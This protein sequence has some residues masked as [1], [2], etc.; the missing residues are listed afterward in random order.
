MADSR[1]L[2]LLLCLGIFF[3]SP[4]FAKPSLDTQLSADKISIDEM[5]EFTIQT[6]WPRQEAQY[7]FAIPELPVQNLTV[8]R[9]GQS[10][11]SFRKGE[12][13]WVRKTFTYE[14]KPSVTGKTGIREFEIPYIDPVLQKGGTLLV[15][16]Q[17]LEVT[18]APLSNR[19]LLSISLTAA[20]LF[21][22]GAAAFLVKARKP[23]AAPPE[24]ITPQQAAAN[25]IKSLIQNAEAHDRTSMLSVIGAEF[26]DF[27]RE[28]YQLPGPRMADDEV[29]AE[30]KRKN[31]I[32]E[33]REKIKIIFNRLQEAQF[34][35]AGVTA[36][37]LKLLQRDI[38]QFVE[39][40]KIYGNP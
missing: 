5:A 30:L 23:K 25:K 14:L 40:K 29:I 17:E 11:E 33:D 26:R 2:L 9:Q 21:A 20:A 18:K 15:G 3:S 27:L 38:L 37:D 36:D 16:A 12:E 8:V 35:G 31:V 22:V 7:S 1:K 13:D 19:Q 10:Q 34:M 6:A 39:G 28:N 32:V 24:T 4:L